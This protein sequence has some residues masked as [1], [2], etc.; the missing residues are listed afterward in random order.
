VSASGWPG[1]LPAPHPEGP[2][3]GSAEGAA[4]RLGNLAR[5]PTSGPL[6]LPSGLL[7]SGMRS[8][9]G[10]GRK[11]LFACG[12]YGAYGVDVLAR[13]NRPYMD[14]S[15]KWVVVRSLGRM[16]PYIR[17]LRGAVSAPGHHGKSRAGGHSQNNVL[18]QD[19][20]VIGLV[21]RRSDREPSS[22]SFEHLPPVG[23]A[24]RRPRHLVLRTKATD[25]STHPPSWELTELQGPGSPLPSR[26]TPRTCLPRPPGLEKASAGGSGKKRP[27]Y[28]PSEFVSPWSRSWE[29]GNP[30][31]H[32]ARRRAVAS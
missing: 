13:A 18:P 32:A 2:N 6:D 12:S 27:P 4:A 24:A 14:S 7:P 20:L 30:R 10:A 26:A 1:M 19:R 16:Q 5:V 3:P 25:T 23:H 11:H 28:S 21:R 22:A 17:P 8:G 31:G 29:M 15:V 9:T